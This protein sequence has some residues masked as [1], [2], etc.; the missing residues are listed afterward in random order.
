MT[1]RLGQLD[2]FWKK[3]KQDTIF[4]ASINADPMH[5]EIAATQ[6]KLRCVLLWTG[7]GEPNRVELPAGQTPH[8]RSPPVQDISRWQENPISPIPRLNICS[9]SHILARTHPS[10]CPK[11]EITTKS[12]KK[13]PYLKKRALSWKRVQHITNELRFYLWHT[14]TRWLNGT[15]W[16]FII[17]NHNHNHH[18]LCAISQRWAIVHFS[19]SRVVENYWGAE[20]RGLLSQLLPHFVCM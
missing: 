20:S 9:A 14:W 5:Y 10:F 6:K 7:P 4:P 16:Y 11:D 13:K 17:H 15:S 19:R 3:K 12:L 18:W 1:Q 8:F 2:Q